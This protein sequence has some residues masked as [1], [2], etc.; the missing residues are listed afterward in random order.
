MRAIEV[1]HLLL[2]AESMATPKGMRA[3]QLSVN[4]TDAVSVY[5]DEQHIL[6][7]LRLDVPTEKDIGVHRSKLLC[8]SRQARLTNWD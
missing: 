5:S 4:E 6:L 3:V 8:A 2:R 7:Q 1:Q